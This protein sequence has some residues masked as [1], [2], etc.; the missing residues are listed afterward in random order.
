LAIII[1]ASP[2][3]VHMWVTVSS[4]SEKFSY[5]NSISD[6]STTIVLCMYMCSHD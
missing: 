1:V 6:S 2:N 3:D 4:S 5:G